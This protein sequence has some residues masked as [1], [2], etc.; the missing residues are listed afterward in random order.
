MYKVVISNQASKDIEALKNRN[1]LLIKKSYP[2]SKNYT[3]IPIQVPDTLKYYAI[4]L[5]DIIHGVLPI[6]IVLFMRS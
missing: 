2:F 1:L 3:C 5:P 4:L 6:S